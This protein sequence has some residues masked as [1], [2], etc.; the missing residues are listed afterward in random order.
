MS[1]TKNLAYQLEGAAET[2]IGGLIGKGAMG[3]KKVIS[4][5]WR[6]YDQVQNS[7]NKVEEEKPTLRIILKESDG[8]VEAE[9]VSP[10]E[11]MQK[12]AQ[13][14]L[15]HH[16]K[17]FIKSKSLHSYSFVAEMPHHLLGQ[18]IGKKASGLNRLL[19]DVCATNKQLIDPEDFETAKTARLRIKELDF[20]S[21]KSLNEFV[22]KRRNTSFIGWPP[23][24]EDDYT[25]HISLTVTFSPKAEPLVDYQTYREQLQE[26]IRSR[27]DS[28]VQQN[29]EQMVEINQALGLTD[30]MGGADGTSGTDE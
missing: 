21:V 1:D 3:L 5:T 29:E 6:K 25:E 17:E 18:L 24:E 15:N 30:E 2:D 11:T 7:E 4:G 20:D 27:V 13:L 8:N 10:S 23:S 16:V 12:L 28:I 26:I 14:T 9:I 22:E 19:N